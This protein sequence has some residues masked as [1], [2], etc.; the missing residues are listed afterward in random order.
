MMQYFEVRNIKEKKYFNKNIIVR[1]VFD[2]LNLFKFRRKGNRMVYL[3]VQFIIGR[4][5]IKVSFYLL[6]FL[7]KLYLIFKSIIDKVQIMKLVIELI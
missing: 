2:F 4:L 1:E 3:N 5:I 7:L 6:V